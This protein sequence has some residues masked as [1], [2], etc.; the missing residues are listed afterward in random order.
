MELTDDVEII[1]VEEED[2]LTGEEAEDDLVENIEGNEGEAPNLYDREKENDLKNESELE[3]PLV[4][5]DFIDAVEEVETT[6]SRG[7]IG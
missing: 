2:A 4:E 6:P 1:D 7:R 3:T 5:N